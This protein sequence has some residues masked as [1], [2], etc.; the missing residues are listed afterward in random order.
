MFLWKKNILIIIIVCVI[1]II[2]QIRSSKHRSNQSVVIRSMCLS[3]HAAPFSSTL[4]SPG[5][6]EL[7]WCWGQQDRQAHDGGRWRRDECGWGGK[8]EV[9]RTSLWNMGCLTWKNVK[10]SYLLCLLS[11]FSHITWF[12]QNNLEVRLDRAMPRLGLAH[13]LLP[14]QLPVASSIVDT[15]MSL[16]INVLRQ[17]MQQHPQ[18]TNITLI[19]ATGEQDK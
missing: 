5:C 11:Q 13:L 7:I 2:T 10:T 14:L 18:S 15:L 17:G 16:V 3:V 6:E 1:L 12:D 19:M 4:P 8:L 9:R